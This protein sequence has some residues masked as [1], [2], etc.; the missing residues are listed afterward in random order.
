MTAFW[1][2]KDI[3]S[4]VHT[5]MYNKKQIVTDNIFVHKDGSDNLTRYWKHQ[6]HVLDELEKYK[7]EHLAVVKP[8]PPKVRRTRLP[9]APKW[10]PPRLQ[11]VVWSPPPLSWN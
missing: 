6:A 3:Q 9:V 7:N 2:R 10:K 1:L 5:M 4:A 11:E 8:K